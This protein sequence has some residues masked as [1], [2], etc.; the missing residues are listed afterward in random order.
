M[1]DPVEANKARACV[2]RRKHL[3]GEHVAKGHNTYSNAP[4]S[5]AAAA[6]TPN[7]STCSNL[8]AIKTQSFAQHSGSSR[9]RAAWTRVPQPAASSALPSLVSRHPC[10]PPR[11]PAAREASS[12]QRIFCHK[13]IDN[14]IIII[15]PLS[16]TRCASKT[17][18]MSRELVR[19]P[20]QRA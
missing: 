13:Q 11:Y 14:G 8:T 1:F 9:M 4:S 15:L 16:S 3:P 2:L 19:H 20:L 7:T 17:L 12:I 6:I 18:C 5:S 10:P